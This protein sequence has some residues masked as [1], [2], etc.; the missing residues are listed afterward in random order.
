MEVICFVVNIEF[1]H[2]SKSIMYKLIIISLAVIVFAMV[3][4]CSFAQEEHIVVSLYYPS[5]FGSY[6]ELNAVRMAVGAGAWMPGS[7]SPNDPV[8]SADAML[9][10]GP[11]RGG[12]K[13]SDSIQGIEL[14]GSGTPYI[15]F[16]NDVEAGNDYDVRI[17][18]NSSGNLEIIAPN[19]IRGVNNCLSLPYNYTG[20]ISAACSSIAGN[21]Q[22][23]GQSY[24][25]A[26]RN[27]SILCCEY[28]PAN[29]T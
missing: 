6:A 25:S 18:L 2:N 1:Y 8:D 27:G 20:T 26:P 23:A 16:S 15:D 4:H 7:A 3:F 9:T 19:G 11:A 10:W 21:Y 12:L 17:W 24:G 22:V 14:G 5:P 29:S 13:S 28:D